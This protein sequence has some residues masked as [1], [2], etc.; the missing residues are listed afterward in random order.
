[1]MK[2]DKRICRQ[3]ARPDKAPDP[4]AG[5]FHVSSLTYIVCSAIK[6]IN[7]H[8]TLVLYVYQRESV[9][10]GN[11]QPMWTMFQCQDDYITLEQTPSGKTHWRV[12]SF[13]RLCNDNPYSSTHP[14][15]FYTTKDIQRVLRFCKAVSNCKD[16]FSAL[17]SLQ[18]TIRESKNLQRQHTRERKIIER[19]QDVPPIPSHLKQWAHENILPAYFF[20]DY[21]KQ[22]KCV[23]GFCTSC[24]KEVTLDRAKHNEKGVCPVC[25]REFTMKA[26]GR[27]GHI[28]DSED[29]QVI[30]KVKNGGLL[31]RIFNTSYSYTV[32]DDTPRASHSECA[33]IFV[34]R[35]PNGQVSEEPYY[36]SY[37]KGDLTPWKHGIR[38][39]LHF[40]YYVRKDETCCKLYW[41]NLHKELFG[42]AWQ[43]CPLEQFYRAD[44]MP[45]QV[46]PFLRAHLTHPRLEHLVKVGF[47][48]LVS[49]LVYGRA[50]EINLDESEHRT[51]RILNVG[52]EDVAYLKEIRA[53]AQKLSDF[54]MYYQQNVKDR[55]EL[56]RWQ[57]DRDITDITHNILQLLPYMTAHKFMR[58]MDRQYD[59][60]Q[61]RLTPYKT[62][63]YRT[64][65][66]LLTEYCDYIRMC[67]KVKYDMKN[68]FVLFP[69]DIQKAHDRVSRQIKLKADAKLRR[70]FKIAYQRITN[71]LDFEQN[72]MRIL[73]PASPDDIIAEG[74]ALHHC[75]GGY[76]DRVA[77]EECII[78]FLRQTSQLEKP[79]YTIEVRNQE[80]V[81]VRGDHNTEATND[82][83]VFMKQ[84]EAAV[85]QQNTM[86]VAA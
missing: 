80:V 86:P 84:W 79:F 75:V 66:A 16:G 78:L 61:H 69:K 76:V 21:R 60:L 20:Y 72:G 8:R 39:S 11:I 58:Y 57:M 59:F 23:I 33:R 56:H 51:H 64:L 34:Q 28:S 73:Y 37:W 13:D 15:A 43:Y 41:K 19:M 49:D 10:A 70:D 55:Q 32:P 9:L 22:A 26:R 44:Q 6:I 18:S 12:S 74:Q 48:D 85:L 27:R 65:A 38:P 30:Q 68:D 53:D 4:N 24:R 7:G 52:A 29:Y 35:L 54:R 5:V 42:T 71:Q 25:G 82:V 67:E 47:Y 2:L 31:I 62:Q 3:Y 83:T 1:M 45:M 63:R 81:Q 46:I 14:Y 17:K 50:Y 40:S 36:N 77:R